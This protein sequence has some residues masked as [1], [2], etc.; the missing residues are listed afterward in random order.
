ML[1]LKVIKDL[2][3]RVQWVEVSDPRPLASTL[4]LQLVLACS[5]LLT[6]L[7]LLLR[8]HST[9][10]QEVAASISVVTEGM[11]A[12]AMKDQRLGSNS[13]TS[14]LP[15]QDAAIQSLWSF[16]RHSITTVSVTKTQAL[17][18][19]CAFH[20]RKSI[21]SAGTKTLSPRRSTSTE[22]RTS[23]WFGSVALP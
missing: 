8:M 1:S 6:S 17:C 19:T 5:A 21:L 7:L 14:M 11:S 22:A 23:Q 10:A 13:S 16:L 3:S 20:K 2:K 9:F 12:Q 4:L 18:C 15:S